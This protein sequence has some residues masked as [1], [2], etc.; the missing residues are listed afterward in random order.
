MFIK[1]YINDQPL[2]LCDKLNAE[3]DEILKHPDVIYIDELSTPAINTLLHEV[4]KEQFHAGVIFHKDFKKLKNTFFKHFN[5]I[6]A[7]GGIVQNEQ[8]EILFIERLGKW[9]LPKGKID[10][11]ENA[12][13]AAAREIEEETGV[14][15]LVLK[16]KIGETYHVYEA[17]GKK[18]IK[19]T[20]W[21]YF[22]SNGTQ[23]NTPQLEENITE[24]KWFST[25]NI[26]EPVANTYPSI[27]D[28]L[29]VFFDTP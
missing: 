19:T 20:Y 28:I 25:K 16:N 9:D 11:G 3:I 4:K 18:N 6:E 5:F 26:K 10:A 2:Y 27:K 8:K 1:V 21:Y 13:I 15:K 17:F 23:R 29:A 14:K 22:E 24:V 7:A 12:E